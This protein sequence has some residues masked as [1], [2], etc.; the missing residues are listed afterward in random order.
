MLPNS[1]R[2]EFTTP[3][4]GKSTPTILLFRNDFF[5]LPPFFAFETPPRGCVNR[6]RSGSV[7]ITGG[8]QRKALAAALA[9]KQKGV[10]VTVGDPSHLALSLWSLRVDHRVIYP[11]P[12]L[13]EERFIDW[14]LR[15]PQALEDQTWLAIQAFEEEQAMPYVTYAER[16][17]M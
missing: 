10:E 11:E 6:N 4:A 1:H 13:N 2:C 7:F 16:R 14:L 5:L 17:G 15:L 9:L 8:V 3:A 12:E